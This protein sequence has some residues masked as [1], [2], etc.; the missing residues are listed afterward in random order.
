MKQLL[1]IKELK[2]IRLSILVIFNIVASGDY[3]KKLQCSFSSIRLQQG[4]Y[5]AFDEFLKKKKREA[6]SY[7]KSRKS[8]EK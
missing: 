6:E 7:R 1:K 4:I 3:D 2:T 8:Y 5:G